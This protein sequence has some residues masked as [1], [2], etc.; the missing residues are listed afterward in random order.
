[1]S[2][3]GLVCQITV[4]SIYRSTNYKDALK[5][6]FYELQSARDWYREVT[7]D[8]GMH[9]DLVPYWTRIAALLVAP[10]AP[11]F[12]EHLY[13]SVLGLPGSIQNA[14]WP[15]P[16]KQVDRTLV[17]AA[18]YMRGV[19]KMMRD[20]EASLLK[21]LSRSKGKGPVMFDPKKPKSV[22]I[23]VATEFPE[24]QDICVDIVKQA[25]S[26]DEN[27][28]DDSKV[29]TL[30]VEKGL[31]KDKRAMPFIQMFKVGTVVVVD[32]KYV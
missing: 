19:T 14:R 10:I 9:E 2:I 3:I 4:N 26:A 18:S 30:L 7:A 17:E 28:V 8:V 21:L 5:Y 31:I 13:C 12:A 11:H 27:K 15:T 16:D 24:W 23:Y 22:R 29:K 6:G 1:M 20:A 25:Y 32:K